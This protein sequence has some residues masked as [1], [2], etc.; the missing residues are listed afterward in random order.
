MSEEYKKIIRAIKRQ[1]FKNGMNIKQTGEA[2]GVHRATLG[3]YLN[4]N[5]AMP[6]DI[7]IRAINFFGIDVCAEI[8][9]PHEKKE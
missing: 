2:L 1:M 7:L 4:I 5:R 3:Q 6:G 8:G 9:I